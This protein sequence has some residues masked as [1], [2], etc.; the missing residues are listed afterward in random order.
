M[1]WNLQPTTTTTGMTT[2]ASGTGWRQWSVATQ[3]QAMYAGTN[4]GFLVR[5]AT[6]DAGSA[7]L[8]TFSSRQAAGNRPE[9]LITF[10]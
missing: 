1:T 4:Y 2:T 9:L 3:V 10:G 5:D 8:Q 6:E 7:Q